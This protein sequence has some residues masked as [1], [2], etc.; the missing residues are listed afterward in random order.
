MKVLA[1]GATGQYAGLVVPAL[2]TRGVTV[3]AV[4][5]DP[6][7][8]DAVTAAGA[9]ETVGADLRDRDSLVAAMDGV[10]GVYCILPAFAPDTSDLGVAVV[11]AAR[12]AGVRRFVYSGVYHPSLSLVNHA[13][14][15]PVEEAVY[16]SDLTFTVLQPAMY[17]QGLAGSWPAARDHG[18]L[19]M[20][21]SRHSAM[22][23]VDFRDVADVAALAFTDDRLAYG[24][25]EL[26]AAGM[27]DRTRIAAL[28]SRAAGREVEA[29]DQSLEEFAEASGMPPGPMRDGLEA[30]FT[31]YDRVGFHGGNDLV[32]R[33][34]LGREPRTL[35]AYVA[36]LAA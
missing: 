13:D 26:A 7:K 35:E 3:R 4:V 14:T 20:P 17:M 5:H 15:R 19:S 21:Y 36:E 18:V 30:M 29:R 27:A 12:H 25:F 33:T 24:T 22:S 34:V 1:L 8:A 16:A 2:K 32:L 11:E 28:M 23:W 31:S 6:D 9:D 10:D